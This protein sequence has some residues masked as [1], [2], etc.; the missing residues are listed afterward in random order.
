[1]C[2]AKH[3]IICGLNRHKLITLQN[4][5]EKSDMR[6]PIFVLWVIFSM[7]LGWITGACSQAKPSE[8][9]TLKIAVL[10]VLDVLPLYVA[11]QENL[12]AKH[13]VTIELIPVGSAPE[14]DQIIAAGQ[15]DGMINEAVST[16]FYNKDQVQVQIVRYARVATAT[17]A[18]FH[19]M[20]AKDSGI[21]S[22]DGLRN[23][24][25]GV[26]QGTVIEYLTDRLLE[27][28]GFRADEIKTIPVPKISDR[29]ALLGSGEL[30]AATLPDPLSFL[31]ESQ[32][33]TIILE[34]SAIPDY[35]FSVLTFRKAIIDAHPQAIRGFLAAIEEAVDKINTQPEAYK[36]LLVEQ[37]L[38]PEPILGA[39]NIP[40]FPK[41]GVPTEAQWAD[42]LAWAKQKGLL[43]KDVAYASSVNGDYLP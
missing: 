2:Q 33:A 17:S 8:M 11:Q 4:H 30:K 31:V 21:T 23:V 1:M 39:Y 12:Y 19:I 38:V 41:A 27:A 32:G 13:G 16:L 36:N 26:S 5:L 25:I 42:A 37:K 7:L 18:M 14:R 15:A 22:P 10:P 40:N 3:A 43:D 9:V 29:M 34:D 6:K 24:P 20:A 28:Q 35:A